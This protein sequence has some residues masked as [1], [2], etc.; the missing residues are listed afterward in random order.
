MQ[1][2]ELP[3]NI[4][5]EWRWVV[6]G[7]IGILG[8]ILGRGVGGVVGREVWVRWGRVGGKRVL[9]ERG[10]REVCCMIRVELRR[11]GGKVLR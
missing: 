11:D 8:K 6:G 10:I 4:R 5:S 1:E 7:I 3:F 9:A 2:G